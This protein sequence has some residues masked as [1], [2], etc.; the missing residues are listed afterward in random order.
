MGVWILFFALELVNLFV[1]F[2]FF[3]GLRVAVR[4]L[5]KSGKDPIGIGMLWLLLLLFS[6]GFGFFFLMKLK[7]GGRLG[8]FRFDR[9]S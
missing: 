6:L 4:W 8:E 2:L 5:W 1:F 9:L 7:G 3:V